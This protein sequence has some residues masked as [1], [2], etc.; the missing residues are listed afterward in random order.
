MT[1]TWVKIVNTLW[2]MIYQWGLLFVQVPTWHFTFL[3]RSASSMMISFTNFYIM[4]RCTFINA[5][6]HDRRTVPQ[7]HLHCRLSVMSVQSVHNSKI[8]LLMSVSSLVFQ[9]KAGYTAIPVADGWARV[10][11]RVL[12][13]FDSWS[14]TDRPTDGSNNEGRIGCNEGR[15]DWW[16]D[17][18]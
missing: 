18:E 10:D 6:S 14:R 13:L 1:N 9:N 11:M 8:S 3:I 17:K 12:T 4:I 7:T 2:E 5:K 15:M 16:H